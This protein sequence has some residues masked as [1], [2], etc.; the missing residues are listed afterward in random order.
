MSQSKPSRKLSPTTILTLLVIPLVL[1]G[2]GW[3]MWQQLQNTPTRQAGVQLPPYGILTV[4]LTTD[5]F[6][7][8]A[9]GPVQMTLRLQAAGGQLAQVD[10]VTYTYGPEDGSEEYLGQAQAVGPETF[11]G[12]LRFTHVGDWWVKVRLEYQGNSGE[13]E[14]TVPVK[15]AL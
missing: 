5:P 2:T 15:P 14:F 9:T 12:P 11:Q 7:A 3:T 4:Q 13:V 10:R 8:L 1:I 6:P